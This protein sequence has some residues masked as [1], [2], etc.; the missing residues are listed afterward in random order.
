[1]AVGVEV[2]KKIGDEVKQGEPIMIIHANDENKAY[3]LITFLRESYTFTKE[4]V[5]KPQEILGIV[6]GE[7]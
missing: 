3:S 2:L 4:K 5:E 6:D 7:N 1:M